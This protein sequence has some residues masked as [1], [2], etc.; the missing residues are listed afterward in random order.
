MVYGHFFE[1]LYPHLECASGEVPENVNHEPASA[2]YCFIRNQ[3]GIPHPSPA[4]SEL[5]TIGN[6]ILEL[7]V[8]RK[9]IEKIVSSTKLPAG[10]AD[11]YGKPEID[12]C[13]YTFDWDALRESSEGAMMIA[14]K[15]STFHVEYDAVKKLCSE[16]ASA[17]SDDEDNLFDD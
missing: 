6:A 12:G 11:H 13:K 14:D 16:L 15:S 9:D 7:F 4:P 1:T 5:P 3:Y 8:F 17:E 10:Y 2:L